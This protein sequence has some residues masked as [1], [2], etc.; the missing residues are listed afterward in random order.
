MKILAYCCLSFTESVQK[1]TGVVPVTS[2]P[3]S[4]FGGRCLDE[5]PPQALDG[6]D[7]IYF[8][9][10]GLPTQP[11]WYGDEM[12]TALTADQIRA[13]DLSGTVVF[14]ANCHLWHIVKKGPQH[15]MLDALLDAGAQAVVGGGGENFGKR[16]KIYG[17]DLL[18][19]WFVM[20]YRL[21]GNPLTSLY[22]A[23]ARVSLEDNFGARDALK[24]KLFTQALDVPVK[25]TGE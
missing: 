11:Y 2:P 7:L 13:A 17:A 12:I 24:F 4:A 6:Y 18:G 5:F 15:P 14:V 19:K 21:C 25:D 20:A 16:T 3:L 8:K 10:H 23:K 9:L 22:V 1:A